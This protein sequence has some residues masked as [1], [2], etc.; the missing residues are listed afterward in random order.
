MRFKPKIWYPIAAVLAVLN[1]ASI[2]FAAG[3]PWHALAHGALA[4]AFGLWAQR[5]KQRR[6]QGGDQQSLETPAGGSDR[7]EGLEDE[8]TRLRQELS[9]AQERLDFTERML[10]QRAQEPPR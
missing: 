9:E 3:E 8:V 6:D 4:V 5:L 7:I 2:P 1:V 10:T